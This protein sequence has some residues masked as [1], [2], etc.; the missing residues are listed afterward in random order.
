MAVN[1]LVSNELFVTASDYLVG[2]GSGFGF[3]AG[4]ITECFHR[5]LATELHWK[6]Y[7]QQHPSIM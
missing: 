7:V 4:T 5:W 6:Q 2:F 1:E 3:C